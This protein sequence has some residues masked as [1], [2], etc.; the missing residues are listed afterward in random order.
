MR[1]ARAH[2]DGHDA[3]AGRLHLDFSTSSPTSSVPVTPH[4]PAGQHLGQLG[5]LVR[6]GAQRGAA[7]LVLALQRCQARVRG[8]RALCRRRQLRAQCGLARLH[9]RQ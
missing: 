1:I 2:R 9:R 7:L 3:K 6:G 4:K 8:A 5:G